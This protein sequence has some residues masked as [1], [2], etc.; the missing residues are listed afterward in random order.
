MESGAG[1]VDGEG[2]LT[3]LT[4]G[5]GPPPPH[6][7]QPTNAN[8]APAMKSK[9]GKHQKLKSKKKPSSST[10]PR[11]SKGGGKLTVQLKKRQTIIAVNRKR[12]RLMTQ[13]RSDNQEPP[14][15]SHQS[16][17][18]PKSSSSSTAL[19]LSA[20]SSRKRTRDSADNI[21]EEPLSSSS[22]RT[23]PS[24]SSKTAKGEPQ[25]KRTQSR[26]AKRKR[27][28]D[29]WDSGAQERLEAS[30]N[31]ER[32]SLASNNNN[33][34]ASA[35]IIKPA[36]F[37]GESEEARVKRL[38]AQMG[39]LAGPLLV[40]LWD[41][42]QDL[43]KNLPHQ[44]AAQRTQNNQSHQRYNFQDDAH[45]DQKKNPFAALASDSENDLGDEKLPT[46]KQWVQ[47]AI[48]SRPK[49]LALPSNPAEMLT[50][51]KR[52]LIAPATLLLPPF[53]SANKNA[54]QTKEDDEESL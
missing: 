13:S 37:E 17:N 2:G 25:L 48:L 51:A 44:P 5:G 3:F 11:P 6:K 32:Q 21:V 40:S 49:A 9:P 1:G 50:K 46:T 26:D 47:P 54:P 23:T 28:V 8:A 30:L 34:N 31:R 43:K 20:P 27:I 52:P 33:N 41:A 45:I 10:Q 24:S 15:K 36:T 14:L 35:S 42:D 22:K 12:E 18:K 16:S 29:E 53:Q 19:P 4:W 38:G 39:D 7:Q